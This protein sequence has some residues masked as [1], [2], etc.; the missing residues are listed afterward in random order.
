M[1]YREA[2]FEA[3]SL[4]KR[5]EED[6][7]RLAQLTWEQVKEAGKSQRQ[8]AEDIDVSEGHARFMV[9]VWATYGA[10]P[11]RTR[12][13]FRDAY[14]EA[15]G[16]PVDAADRRQM[17]AD[18]NVA[19]RTV[20]DKAK[21]AVEL[22]EDEEVATEVARRRRPVISEADRKAADASTHQRLQ[23]IRQGFSRIDLGLAVEALQEVVNALRQAVADDA[24]DPDIIAELDAV[25]GEYVIARQEADF[26]LGVR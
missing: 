10:Y 18:R 3:R 11:V 13:P 12:P 5:S 15:K 25:H 6:Q 26:K 7:W 19:N 22:L 21:L 8:W 17:E 1:N 24:V 23:P 16:L 4:V 9:K 20:E 14:A 2:V